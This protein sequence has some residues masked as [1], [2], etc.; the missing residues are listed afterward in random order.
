MMGV[1]EEA[2]RRKAEREAEATRAKEAIDKQNADIAEQQKALQDH[3]NMLKEQMK[4]DLEHSAKLAEQAKKDAE[5]D[6]ALADQVKKDAEH[7]AA[8]ADQVK[9]DAEHDAA[10]ADQVKK[11]AEHDAALADQ[12][13]KDAEHDAT[14]KEQIK[15]DAEHDAKL[16]EHNLAIADLKSHIITLRQ[17]IETKISQLKLSL[18]QKDQELEALIKTKANKTDVENEFQRV[19]TDFKTKITTLQNDIN[20]KTNDLIESIKNLKQNVDT[21]VTELKQFDQTLQIQLN[22]ID[23][24]AKMSKVSIEGLNEKFDTKIALHSQEIT[25]LQEKITIHGDKINE[26]KT[27][28]SDLSKKLTQEQKDAVKKL[29]ND[30]ATKFQNLKDNELKNLG[31]QD[32]KLQQSIT[33]IESILNATKAA[34]QQEITDTYEDLPALMRANLKA[35]KTSIDKKEAKDVVSAKV[36]VLADSINDARSQLE[37]IVKDKVIELTQAIEK[38]STARGADK[39]VMSKFILQIDKG[40]NELISKETASLNTKLGEHLK[41]YGIEIRSLKSSLSTLD[42]KLTNLTTQFNDFISKDFSDLKKELGDLRDKK[43]QEIDSELNKLKGE[44]TKVNQAIDDIKG[45]LKTTVEKLG[46]ADASFDKLPAAIVRKLAEMQTNL[47][48]KNNNTL[49]DAQKAELQQ[50]INVEKTKILEAQTA[51]IDNAKSGLIQQ[52]KAL[53]SA[54]GK[55]ADV[56]LINKKLKE[57]EET[58]LKAIGEKLT[59]VEGQTNSLVTKLEVL[60]QSV[61]GLKDSV[62]MLNDAMKALPTINSTIAEL[63]TQL[64]KTEGTDDEQ[65]ES[66]TKLKSFVYEAQKVL[67]A[68][69]IKEY[70]EKLSAVLA[71]VDK[72]VSIE[73]LHTEL[74]QVRAKMPT[75]YVKLQDLLDKITEFK[76]EFQTALQ[77]LKDEDAANITSLTNGLN[78]QLNLLRSSLD[79]V[80]GSLNDLSQKS[81]PIDEVTSKVISDLNSDLY[82]ILSSVGKA[83]LSK[84]SMHLKDF[85][86]VKATLVDDLRISTDKFDHMQKTLDDIVKA[87]SNFRLSHQQKIQIENFMTELDSKAET[88]VDD[89]TQGVII[90]HGGFFKAD[91]LSETVQALNKIMIKSAYQHADKTALNTE[92]DILCKMI[93]KNL[94]VGNIIKEIKSASHGG[95][96]MAIERLKNDPYL[97]ENEH[98]KSFYNKDSVLLNKETLF[99]DFIKALQTELNNNGFN[100]SIQKQMKSLNANVEDLLHNLENLQTTNSQHWVEAREKIH[101][102]SDIYT[103]MQYAEKDDV[104]SDI[105]KLMPDFIGHDRPLVTEHFKDGADGSHQ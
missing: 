70:G 58:Q 80:E 24:F 48:Q 76:G 46:G 54:G 85:N 52:M 57:I 100:E 73:S 5:H 1:A 92:L 87:G 50:L 15:K 67:G 36:Q 27:N 66:I 97:R 33:A 83:D 62:T 81:Q 79:N 61:A 103:K 40:L 91:S 72:G 11:D 7:D 39:E 47:L 88:R 38:E 6:A 90:K 37:T 77:S 63:K 64:T 42:Q 8:I 98:I 69:D 84:L 59:K 28:L 16:A 56:D 82:N 99:S 31:E 13:K 45:T 78:K 60:E 19:E 93:P 29:E 25:E 23:E 44:D 95:N 18:E 94:T 101:S 41:E 89:S 21:E 43:L 104:K 105:H 34:L 68:K 22:E 20:A 14:F 65:R 35:I 74:Q 71:K 2:K 30:I 55:Q 4:K 3:A 51:A 12:V 10:I 26:L 49:L 17:E 102:A 32:V 96:Y 9:K 86:S 53:V 75:D